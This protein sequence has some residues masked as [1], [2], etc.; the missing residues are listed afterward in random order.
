M[1]SAVTEKV[2]RLAKGRPETAGNPLSGVV[3]VPLLWRDDDSGDCSQWR[4]K[5]REVRNRPVSAFVHEF[6]F[7]ATTGEEPSPSYR[8]RRGAY[9]AMSPTSVL[10]ARSGTI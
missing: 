7:G 4:L 6:P 1:A 10:G 5:L 9:S 2:G 8:P 3:G